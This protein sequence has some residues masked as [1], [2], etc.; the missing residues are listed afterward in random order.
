MLSGVAKSAAVLQSL[1][2]IR[3][4]PLTDPCDQ[5][6]GIG[7]AKLVRFRLYHN[8]DYGLGPAFAQKDPPILSQ[9]LRQLGQLAL[10]GGIGHDRLLAC[11]G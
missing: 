10:H 9:P 1:S 8:A 11:N 6:L 2:A 7:C 4:P 5:F 3:M